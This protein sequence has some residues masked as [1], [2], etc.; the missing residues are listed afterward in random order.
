LGFTP[1]SRLSDIR[2]I[3]ESIDGLESGF[4]SLLKAF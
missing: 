3:R 2:L 4:Y 1:D